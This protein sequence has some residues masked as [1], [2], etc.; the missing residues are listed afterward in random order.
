MTTALKAGPELNQ[1][2]AELSACG[3]RLV[4]DG[5]ALRVRGA[6]AALT[7]EL[8][9]RI[10]AN[11]RELLVL[12][13]AE[14]AGGA[15]ERIAPRA[16]GVEVPLSFLQQNLWLIDQLEGSVQYNMAAAI[17]IDGALDAAALERALATIVRRHESLRTVFVPGS[18]GRAVQ[19]VR[20]D[21]HF[22]LTHADLSALPAQ[23][24]EERMRALYSEEAR[25]PFD[26]TRDMMLRACLLR[27]DRDGAVLLFTLHHIAGD[28]WSMDVLLDEMSQLYAAIVAGRP[29]PLPP[30]PVQYGDYAVW[31]VDRLQGPELERKLAYWQTRLAGLPA[32]HNLPLDRPR[33]PYRTINGGRHVR[34]WSAPRANALHAL[35]S[36]HEVTLFMLLE[37]ALAVLLARWSGET[38]IA[39]GTPVSSRTRPELAP[40]IGY[41]T[42]TLVLRSDCDPDLTFTQMLRQT[43]TTM[44]DAHEHHDIPFEM[45]V[46]KLNPSRSLAHSAL[47]QVI[48][49]LQNNRAA[50]FGSL[51]LAG[52]RIAP[53]VDGGA[54]SVKFDLELT[55]RELPDG[56]QLKWDY[57]RDIF[58]AATIESLDRHYGL[59]LDAVLDDADRP[60]WRLAGLA[61]EDA[62]RL[63]AWNSTER[64]FGAAATLAGMV[65]AQAA[66]TPQAVALIDGELELSYGEL[67]AR[68][69]RLARHLLALH[70]LALGEPVGHCVAR[71]AAMVVAL[72]AIMK[73]GGAY[74]ALDAGLPRERL[75]YMLAD[76]GARLLIC[77]GA[78]A[79]LLAP[80]PG[81]R[82]LV[83][84]ALALSDHASDDLPARCRADSLAYVIYT[85][86]STGRPKGTLNL[87]RGPCNRIQAM[88]RQFGL[89]PADR[90]LQKT[91]LSFDVSVWELFWPLSQGAALVLASP[92]GHKDPAWLTQA[93]RRHGVT[94]M[95]FVPSM[96]GAFLHADALPSLPS[97]RYVMT[98]GEALSAELQAGAIAAFP[99]V[100]LVNQYGPTEAAVEVSW[101]RFNAARADRLVPLGAPIDNVRLHVLDAHDRQQP[102]GVAGELHIAGIQVGEGYL[103]QPALT[104]ERFVEREVAGRL[105]RLY[106]TGDRARWL[107]DGQLVYMG[108]LDNQVKLRGLRIELGE[109]EAALREEGS[110]S[111]A[112]VLLWGEADG[113]HQRLV[114]YLA[115]GPGR[116]LDAVRDRVL[117]GLRLRLPEYMIPAQLVALEAL[118]V[119]QNGKLD[120]R[121]LPPPP[122][123]EQ[124]GDV[125]AATPMEEMLMGLW[126]R[127]LA[128]PPAGVHG[129][130]FALGGHSLLATQLA[131]LIRRELGIDIALRIVFEYP[132]LRD[133][134][135]WLAQQSRGGAPAPIPAYPESA[136]AL[137]NAQRRL[138]LLGQLEGPKA[139]YN[140][141]RVLRLSGALDVAALEAAFAEVVRRHANL[142]LCFPGHEGVPSIALLP[143]Y[144]PLRVEDLRALAPARRAQVAQ[145][146]SHAHA[147]HAF[148]LGG[149]ALLR[150]RLLIL[151][152]EEHLLLVN[153]HHIVS[154]GWSL[155]VMMN[156]VS[157]LYGAVR[158]GAQAAGALPALP[159][160]YGDYALWQRDWLSGERLDR[161]RAYWLERLGGAPALLELP[162]DRPRPPQFDY[163]GAI[164]RATL[165]PEL[166]RQVRALSR[167]HGCTMFMTVLAAFNL[168]LARHSGQ[169]DLCVGT[170]I[171]GRGH[172]QTEPLIGF[173]VNTL[174]MRARIDW[175]QD[176]A[177]MLG[178]TRRN[179]LE[180]YQHQDFPFDQ[181]VEALRPAR[182]MAYTPLFQV[183]FRYESAALAQVRMPGLAVADVGFD[184]GSAQ[185]DLQ[186]NVI[187][188]E[189]GLCCE[190]QYASALFDPGSVRRLHVQLGHLLAQMAGEGGDDIALGRLT[191]CDEAG[192]RAMLEL[193]RGAA[194]RWDAPMLMHTLFEQQAARTPRAPALRD[195]AQRLNYAQANARANALAHRLIAL[196]VGPDVR[197][198]ICAERSVEMVIGLL[199]ILKAGGAY[200]PLDPGHPVARLSHVLR[201]SGAA[202]LLSEPAPLARLGTPSVPVLLLGEDRSERGDDPDPAAQGLTAGHLAYVI[203]TS[204]STGQPK[205]ALNQHGGSSNHLLWAR[206]YFALDGADRVLQ[207]TPVGFDVSVWEIFLPL[208]SGAEL[209]MARPSGHSDPAYL[210]DTIV[211]SGV[212]LAHFVPS[213]LAA[214]LDHPRAYL[215]GS[216]RTVVCSGEAL[217]YALYLRFAAQF[218][219]VALH[220]LYGPTET[221]VHATFQRC[222][223]D[224]T[225]RGGVIG[226][227]IAN[228]SIYLLDARGQLVPHGVAGELHI[229]GAG[230]GRGYLNQ[231]ELTAQR[232]VA[233]PFA[234]G[235]AR[236]YRSGD[237]AR[238]RADGALEYLGRNDFQVKLRGLRIEL[239]EI[240]SALRDCAGVRDA[241]VLARADAAG[242]ARLVAY[243]LADVVPA[244]ATLRA[245]LAERLP[246]YML[247]SI[248]IAL[249]A[250]PLTASGKLDRQ[251]LPAPAQ[252][253]LAAA[254]Y[255][256]PMGDTEAAL[257]AIWC[258]LLGVERVGRDDHFF[259]LG[260]HSM[261][262]TRCV[263]RVRDVFGVALPLVEIFRQPTLRACADAIALRALENFSAQ[264]V[265]G[266][267]A[268]L[269]TLSDEE[270]E[271]LLQ[272][273][274]T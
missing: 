103:N 206:D 249:G 4:A 190:W 80:G 91:P 109:I 246:E 274:N 19:V 120:R 187:E 46:D 171:A 41:L 97:L 259:D 69:N 235:L 163:R 15:Q 94:V 125:A 231:P 24:R 266:T 10:G 225:G 234:G 263:A 241:A 58:D 203:Y 110:A 273:E 75:A 148:D 165:P 78:E 7:P 25:R 202:L 178:A 264:D 84:D 217:P 169:D 56:L 79:A 223:P 250:W 158:A 83:L 255:T 30:L 76:S 68:A 157:G 101:W 77:G 36:R 182:S 22:T 197:V 122:E 13:Y 199:A 160:Q 86:G 23:A 257:A 111:D 139:T 14:Q 12:L 145:R 162:L 222:A 113:V 236:M 224:P 133:Q 209:L 49:T 191:L 27:L 31:L 166:A 21:A 210:V 87:H 256:A 177:A 219:D 134:A 242:E 100:E 181:L 170:P 38:D 93:V 212:T 221:A 64:D 156:E 176:V 164:L 89:G 184:G 81:V 185:F 51:D 252:A 65:E 16:R 50:T 62:A 147:A 114:A 54:G 186:L 207:K 82:V 142:R 123:V 193:G 247:P 73:A 108:R 132:V 213:M 121:A 183:M 167:R 53:L 270:L 218:P 71:S 232:F 128:H 154:D 137:S 116:S 253:D 18:Q 26:L 59:L 117:A 1:L 104:A 48:L 150:V 67:N 28:G 107:A 57:N 239:G 45:L 245:T 194:V 188:D 8:T 175:E 243:L 43:R 131:S 152:E 267:V 143:A 238:W 205:G 172:H 70:P 47:V 258:E 200:V 136:W 248:F 233:D 226:R 32:V 115:L 215:C 95:H 130:F 141:P 74:V 72:L 244:S 61:G 179:A 192:R 119:G 151:D 126:T 228:T 260:G 198:A 269:D 168:L 155:G 11:K 196:G 265:A 272:Q 33:P 66:L 37:A 9:E 34:P 129:H 118:P 230:V 229:A 2:L 211:E 261:L 98:S 208:L 39:I 262:A 220:D 35:C 60:L 173:F 29:D 214:F 102:V 99:G 140:I 63:A 149:E 254:A 189:S 271:R 90:V 216:L 204:G 138:W 3:I 52:V 85:S 44:L 92:D 105:E 146:R 161:Q 251:A 135:R 5:D 96:L 42:N 153:M 17:R 227:P 106:R 237:M 88:Q 127:V 40:L 112:V 144:R 201:D 180:A 195:A 240:E 174:V 159:I 124:A 6:R 55:V 268:Q 20:D